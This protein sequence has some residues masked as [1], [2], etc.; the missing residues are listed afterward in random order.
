[1]INLMKLVIGFSGQT[2]SKPLQT[3]LTVSSHHIKPTQKV[4]W[5][6]ELIN[7]I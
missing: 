4:L 2:M 5:F 7:Y 3:L 1:M 6:L